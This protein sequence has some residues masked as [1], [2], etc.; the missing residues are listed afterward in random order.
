MVLRYGGLL[1]LFAMVFVTSVLGFLLGLMVFFLIGFSSLTLLPS[2]IDGKR[3]L[4]V[5][6]NKKEKF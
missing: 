4:L 5:L 6:K 2:W 1:L 3:Y